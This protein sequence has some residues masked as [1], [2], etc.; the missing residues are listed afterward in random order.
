MTTNAIIAN[1]LSKELCFGWDKRDQNGRLVDSGDFYLPPNSYKT[2][3]G[4]LN[5]VL[6]M[7]KVHGATSVTCY[8]ETSTLDMS[9][10]AP[11][12]FKEINLA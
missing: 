8:G 4:V 7:A 6:R 9:Q 12:I 1:L 11:F 10:Q 2:M 5:R 3:G